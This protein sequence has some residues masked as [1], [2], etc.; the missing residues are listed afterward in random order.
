MIRWNVLRLTTTIIVVAVCLVFTLY[1]VSNKGAIKPQLVNH[2]SSEYQSDNDTASLPLTTSNRY[3]ASKQSV[4]PKIFQ[5]PENEESLSFSDAG[6]ISLAVPSSPNRLCT[7]VQVA[8]DRKSF[9]PIARS[10]AGRIWEASGGEFSYL[11]WKCS[12]SSCDVNL[13]RLP[14]GSVFQLTTFFAPVMFRPGVDEVARFLEQATF[15]PT[16]TEI[17]TF[18]L[19]NLPKAFAGWI[20]NQMMNVPVTSHR[21]LFRRKLNAKMETATH[22]GAVTHPCQKGTRYRLYA[23]SSKDYEKYLEIETVGKKRV[24]KIDGFVRTVVD[25][26]I[27]K[28]WDP[29]VTWPDGR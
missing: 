28:S 3:L 19:D 22:N 29:S 25:G 11:S 26:P 15:G 17:S 10:Y 1:F 2:R 21:A 6:K 4:P 27:S 20:N 23:F 5:C 14:T 7:L 24:L 8:S 9:K 18:R 12:S 13:P 16:A